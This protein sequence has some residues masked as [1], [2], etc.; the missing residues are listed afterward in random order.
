MWPDYKRRL[1][2]F[3]YMISISLQRWGAARVA[4]H[5]T[6]VGHPDPTGAG[7]AHRLI[8]VAPRT[9]QAGYVLV[10]AIV[11]LLILSFTLVLAFVAL[12]T[13]NGTAVRAEEIRQAEVLI[14]DLMLDGVNSLTPASGVSGGF[15]WTLQTDATAVSRPVALCSRRARVQSKTSAR[16]YAAGSLVACPAPPP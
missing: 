5:F 13:A 10:D 11:A 3:F 4:S 7:R 6:L 15:T 8:A 14:R 2:G 12:Q 16:A 9:R 1:R